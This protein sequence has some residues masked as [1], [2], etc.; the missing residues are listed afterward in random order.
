MKYTSILYASG[1]LL[2]TMACK[3]EKTQEP[4]IEDIELMIKAEKVAEQDGQAVFHYV[5]DNGDMQVEMTNYG[6]TITKIITPDKNGKK[7]NV[8]LTFDTVEEFLTK[9]NPFFGAT[10]GRIANRIAKGEFTLDGETYKLA[11]NNGPNHLH[12][13]NVG[14]NKKVWAGEPYS[15]DSTIGVKMTYLSVDGEEGYPGNLESTL[16]MELTLSNTLRIQF[17]AETDQKT[18]VNLTNHTYFNLTGVKR[19]VLGH[20]FQFWAD[21][22]TPVDEGL[23]PTGE[24]RDVKGTPFD[25]RDPKIL[26]DQVEA[27]GGGFDHN[28]VMKMEKGSEMK[29]FV[30][31]KDPESG[32]VMDMYSDNV[33]VQFYTA[34]FVSNFEGA[35][36]KIYD[37]QWG[38]CLESQ[39]WPDAINHKNFPSPI[40]NPGEKYEHTIEYKFSVD[41]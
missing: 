16:W 29:H 31:V 38:F 2:L 20:E 3:Q 8:I 14:F 32:R 41:E 13:G 15:N 24:I 23:I 40:L 12:G 33:G 10:A 26:G 39:N 25:F 1:L 22:Y 11:K 4:I 7:E 36:G 34:N 18:I 27:N 17:E 30:H 37:R 21:A 19:N 5:L 35:D 9:S 28:M 6:G